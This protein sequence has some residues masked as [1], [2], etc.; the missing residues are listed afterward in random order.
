MKISPPSVKSN[1][2]RISSLVGFGVGFIFVWGSSPPL[3]LLDFLSCSL[4]SFELR[5]GFVSLLKSSHQDET[6]FQL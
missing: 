3:P 5:F 1:Y 2:F 6:P 4:L